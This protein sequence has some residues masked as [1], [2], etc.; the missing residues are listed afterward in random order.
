MP[1][2]ESP[3]E[4]PVPA[5]DIRRRIEAI[6]TATP[7]YFREPA[8]LAAAIAVWRPECGVNESGVFGGVSEEVMAKCGRGVAAVGV[9]RVR[10]GVFVHCCRLEFSRGGFA[11][12]PTVW[13]AAPH[14]TA[15]AARTA[16]IREL[17]GRLGDRGATGESAAAGAEWSGLRSRLR[18]QIRRPGLFD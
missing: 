4:P 9:G 1:P 14:P 13:H 17:L 16:G 18:G 6:T 12:A 11:Y 8:A 5:A 3:A 7:D 15:E 2:G 10:D